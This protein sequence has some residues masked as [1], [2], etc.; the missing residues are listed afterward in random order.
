MADELAKT[1]RFES[2][3]AC[4]TALAER[5]PVVLVLEDLHWADSTSAELLGFLTRNLDASRVLLIGTYRTDELGRDHRLRPWLSELSRHTRVVPV[6]LEGLDRSEMA[7]M[8]AGIVGH[9]P[10]W[11]L[12]DAVWSRSQGNP[13]FAE[14]LTAARH[15]PSLSP[16]LKGVV[17]HRVDRL[18]AEA[19]QLLRVVAS[20]GPVADAELLEAIGL[21]D[22]DALDARP[23]RGR[24]TVR[25]SSSTRARRGTASVTN[26]CARSCTTRCCRASA[27]GCTALI[28]TALAADPG[29]VVE[30]RA[31]APAPW[32]PL[33]GGGDWTH[34][35]HASIEAAERPAPCG[36]S[37]RP[38][39][40]SSGRCPPSIACL[41]ARWRMAITSAARD[42]RRRRLPGRPGPAPSSWPG[43]ASTGSRPRWHRRGWPGCYILLGRNAWAV[44][45]SDAA[46][47]AYRQACWSCRR[48]RRRSSWP[49]C[50][51]KRLAASC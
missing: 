50:W 44:G 22:A 16:E 20:A 42:G 49:R 24:S 45:D 13:F 34:A 47:D 27:V 1:R 31:T 29:L 26:C 43:G 40:T 33:V 21:F 35:W 2:V 17:M 32:P 39:A 51:P 30:A 38:T 28:A 7:T 4:V 46:F 8:I 15:Q 11:T 23:R 25:S 5:S 14:E 12:V 3:L 10:E 37:P 48:T 19:R 36:P 9:Q 6:R 41:P 18:P